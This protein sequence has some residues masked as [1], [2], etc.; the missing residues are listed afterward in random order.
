M[1]SAGY[2]AMV[3]PDHLSTRCVSD[4]LDWVCSLLL[5][6]RRIP[7]PEA[8]RC[9]LFGLQA[10]TIESSVGFAA[11]RVTR[12][13]CRA[14]FVKAWHPC[15]RLERPRPAAPACGSSG[16]KGAMVAPDHLSTRC[17]SDTLDW[18]CSL[19][20]FCRRIPNP[21]AC[22]CQLFGLQARTIESSVGFAALR[23]TR[24]P[25]RAIFVKAWHPCLR[26]ERPR[27]A[28]PACGS[29]GIHASAGSR[30]FL[31]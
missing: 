10:R 17:V 25:C 9:Q 15:L 13:P 24:H 8:C 11:L 16:I 29:S 26:L 27:P 31:P 30:A 5:F 2:G 23:V 18:V 19:L 22:R 3:A 28:A 21:E 1:G 14:I 4:T 12:H 7:N 6:C 20:L